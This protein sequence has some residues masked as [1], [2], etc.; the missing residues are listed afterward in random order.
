MKNYLLLILLICLPVFVGAQ[1]RTASFEIHNRS[2]I[3][4]TVRD[5]GRLGAPD[6]NNRFENYPSLDWPGGPT[7]M[8]KDDQRHYRVSAGLWIG[9]RRTNGSVF[10]IENGPFQTVNVVDVS[11]ITKETNYLEEPGYRTDEAEE[12]IT[13]EFTTSENLR[14][15]RKSRVWSFR[16]YTNTIFYEYF[17]T[18]EGS[19]PITEVYVGFPNL[20]RPSYQDFVVHNGWGDDFNRVDDLVRYDP[21][22]RMMYTWD[23][24][25]SF[26]LPGDVG[27]YLESAGEL[28]TTGYAGYAILD[29]DPV[30]DGR[31]QPAAT[32]YAQFLNNE[33]FFT[34]TSSSASALYNILN[35][36][37]TSLQA[38][39][40]ERLAPFML[41]SVGPYTISPGETVRIVVG[42]SVN[43]IPQQRALLGLAAQ[44]QLPAGLDSLRNTMT[45]ARTL[46]NNNFQVTSVPPPSPEIT[47]IPNPAEQSVSIYWNPIEDTWSN[48]L[49]PSATLRDYRI[50][51]SSRS[52]IGPYQ[53]LATIRP[54]RPI[55]FNRYYD[56]ANNR[57]LYNDTSISL[58]GEYYYA[59]TSIDTRNVES[60]MTNRN[61]EGIR[62][63][64]EPVDNT[65]S[66]R[67]F[68]NPFK[69]SSGFPN[70]NQ[71]NDIVFTNL[72]VKC[73]IRVYTSSGELVKEIH[74][75]NPNSGEEVWNQLSD[76]RQRTAPGIYFWTVSSDV[77]TATGTLLIVK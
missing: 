32:F 49:H 3:W 21:N 58:G 47:V 27:N 68:P 59:V 34:Q 50:Y 17:I 35:G 70:P 61:E 40:T 31:S 25:P 5:D 26:D 57:W 46:V 11:P 29:Y 60:W 56:A 72:P 10:F 45:R 8:N 62:A 7:V 28:R 4:E 54:S 48:P 18:N 39:E 30:S 43:G 73:T 22:L 16:A 23:D 42:E 15:V 12:T 13:A 55:D 52:F 33:R 37:D 44:A 71:A 6:P 65:S 63:A 36:T 69:L 66:V 41:M 24:T 67:V 9:G 38:S 75:D 74:R 2:N 53:I 76:A 77:G 19:Q 1:T 51:R 14:V 64:R 20:L